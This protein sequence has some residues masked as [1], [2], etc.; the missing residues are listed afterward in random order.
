MAFDETSNLAFRTVSGNRRRSGEE[1][2][3]IHE[4]GANRSYHI[5][6]AF[7]AD[8]REDI[9]NSIYLGLMAY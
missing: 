6:I 9:S 1:L 2:L 5:W 4:H 7:I 3:L 8:N